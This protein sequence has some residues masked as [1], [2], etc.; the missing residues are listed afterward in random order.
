MN[1]NEAN[2][3]ASNEIAK[4]RDIERKNFDERIEKMAKN[5]IATRINATSISSAV[6]KCQFEDE[7]K[8]KIFVC[9]L[10]SCSRIDAQAVCDYMRSDGW[11]VAVRESSHN[12]YQVDVVVILG[13]TK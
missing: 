4:A 5:L 10:T 9:I 6:A 1:F 8:S 12:H 7:K 3:L 13:N 2:S 11:Q